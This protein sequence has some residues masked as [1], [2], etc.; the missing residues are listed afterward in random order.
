ML[1]YC[2]VS[3]LVVTILGQAK[4][5]TDLVRTSG[6]VEREPLPNFFLEHNLIWGS[7]MLLVPAMIVATAKATLRALQSFLWYASV[8]R[9]MN[10]TL[11]VFL[12]QYEGKDLLEG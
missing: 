7:K 11:N 6:V 8:F 12:S 3:K 9:T 2:A 10:V 1:E 4:W 5:A